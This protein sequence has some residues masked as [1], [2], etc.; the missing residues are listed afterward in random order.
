VSGSFLT[1]GRRVINACA[2]QLEATIAEAARGSESH[3]AGYEAI[4]VHFKDAK[5]PQPLAV[6][7]FA[8]EEGTPNNFAGQPD[9]IG[10]G[11]KHDADAELDRD[12]WRF[13]PLTPFSWRTHI[14][15]RYAGMRWL[16]PA[17][18]LDRNEQLAASEITERVHAALHRSGA[19]P[20]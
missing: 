10:I 7:L 15:D 13:R 17:R 16:R 11:L 3:L 4:Y 18:E 8:A 14:D 12:A 5:V 2:S 1:W 19:V 6:W 9:I 20:R